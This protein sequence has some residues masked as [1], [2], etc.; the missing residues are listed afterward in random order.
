MS[1]ALY[2]TIYN[3][4]K[5]DIEEGRYPTALPICTVM[6]LTIFMKWYIIIFSKPMKVILCKKIASKSD[7]NMIVGVSGFCH[8]G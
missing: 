4:Q 7:S 2:Q 6:H 3:E 8:I 1:I 5:R